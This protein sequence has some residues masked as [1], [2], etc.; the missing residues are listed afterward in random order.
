MFGRFLTAFVAIILTALPACADGVQIS[1]DQQAFLEGV[2]SGV[3]TDVS[4]DKLCSTSAP[5]AGAMTLSIEFERSGG[6][7]FADD[8]SETSLRGRITQASEANGV[9]TLTVDEEL[10]RLRPDTDRI[11]ARVRS[12]ASLGGDVDTMVFKRCQKPADRSAIALDDDGLKF[13]ASDLPGDEAFFVD[14]RLVAKTGNRCAVQETQYLFFAL[15]GPSEFR[16]SRWNSF[17]LADRLAA[18]KPVKLPPLDPVAD[19]R[20]DTARFE[21]GKYV[22]RMRD[23]D[24]AKALPETVHIEVKADGISIP[25]WKRNYVRCMGFQSRS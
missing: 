8:G 14:D 9:I 25:E 21:N 2:W 16:L 10:F 17:A 23:Y 7:M 15:I 18:R 11:M 19:W 12:S 3:P 20:I 4:A 5:P 22:L 24:N 13:L 6:V 1:K